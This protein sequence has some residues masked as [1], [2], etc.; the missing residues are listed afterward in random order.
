MLSNVNSCVCVCVC[1]ENWY[2]YFENDLTISSKVD[3]YRKN[4]IQ[5]Q[6]CAEG[7]LLPTCVGELYG[8][9]EVCGM[10]ITEYH[11]PTKISSRLLTAGQ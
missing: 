9:D 3:M 2:N 7:L 11:L 4:E 6:V 5:S 10:P 1:N 8:N